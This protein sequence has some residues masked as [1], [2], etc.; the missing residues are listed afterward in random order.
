[1]RSSTGCPRVLQALGNRWSSTWARRPLPRGGHTAAAVP[2]QGRPLDSSS[3]PP[4]RRPSE[5]MMFRD[6][7]RVPSDAASGL[8]QEPLTGA[9]GRC[10][11]DAE[12]GGGQRAA[13]GVCGVPPGPRPDA[14]RGLRTAS[15]NWLPSPTRSASPPRR[16]RRRP[17][18]P[19]GAAPHRLPHRRGADRGS[20]RR[21]DRTGWNGGCRAARTPLI[22]ARIIHRAGSRVS[23]PPTPPS[24]LYRHGRCSLR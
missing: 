4:A 22:P 17:R 11:G 13:L 15:S 19:I 18:P 21:R 3:R 12:L 7:L 20:S 8:A 23:A 5:G 24:Q 16:G 6:Q 10:R 2:C 14:G 9:G 1:M